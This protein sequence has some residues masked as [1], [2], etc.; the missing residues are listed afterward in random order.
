MVRS[1]TIASV[2]GQYKPIPRP[3]KI[4]PRSKTGKL[5]VRTRATSARAEIAAD[6]IKVFF[7]PK[8][9][10]SAKVPP[11]NLPT[12]PAIDPMPRAKPT[13]VAEIPTWLTKKIGA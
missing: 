8:F 11:R 3:I 2:A 10:A 7:L 1:A 12:T 5:L 4:L 13:A 6:K 9:G